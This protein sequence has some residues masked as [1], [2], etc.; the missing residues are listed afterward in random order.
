MGGRLTVARR[1]LELAHGIREVS[2]VLCNLEVVVGALGIDGQ[3]EDATRLASATGSLRRRTEFASVLPGRARF[4]AA[5]LDLARAALDP[6]SFDELLAEGERLDYD[7]VVALAI[8]GD[9]EPSAA[10]FSAS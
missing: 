6:R 4:L 3:H 5:G 9:S 7:A 1:A 10:T 8:G 2:N